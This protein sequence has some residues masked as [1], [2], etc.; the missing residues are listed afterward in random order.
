VLESL[1]DGSTMDFG[2]EFTTQKSVAGFIPAA[3]SGG[4]G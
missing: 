2:V 4:S 1:N 3:I